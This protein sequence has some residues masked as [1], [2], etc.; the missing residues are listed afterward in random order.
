MCHIKYNIW[1]IKMLEVPS[2]DC[3]VWHAFCYPKLDN[4]LVMCY[5]LGTNLSGTAERL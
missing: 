5:Y 1:Y 3:N 4:D 2:Y